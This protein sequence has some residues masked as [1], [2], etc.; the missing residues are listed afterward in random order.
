MPKSC[1]AHTLTQA[2]HALC[3]NKF[4]LNRFEFDF[5]ITLACRETKKNCSCLSYF[6]PTISFTL[7]V[8]Y[9]SIFAYTPLLLSHMQ[10]IIRYITFIELLF[11]VRWLT[12]FSV[13]IFTP[14]E[15]R[16][17]K[18]LARKHGEIE[19]KRNTKI[20]YFAR[21]EQKKHIFGVILKPNWR[22]HTLTDK[23]THKIYF[24]CNEK[25]CTARSWSQQK[26]CVCA[27]APTKLYFIFQL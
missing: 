24:E 3:A 21:E 8:I 26:L 14:L 19:L 25:V 6:F 11:F 13:V 2:P 1:K 4:N 17:G 23:P 20:S 10:Y 16:S 9:F 27:L 18:K 22:T 5:L 12:Q 15:Q 7:S